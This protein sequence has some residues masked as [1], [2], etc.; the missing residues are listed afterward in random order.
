MSLKLLLI[1]ALEKGCKKLNV[2]GDSM[3]V[4]NWISLTQECRN[5]RLDTLLSSIRMVLQ[6]FDTFSCRHVYRENNM[7]ADVASKEGL[8]MVLGRRQITENRDGT[9]QDYYH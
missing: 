1:F 3:N 5:R 4:I 6:I 9:T 2:F 8:R 7:V